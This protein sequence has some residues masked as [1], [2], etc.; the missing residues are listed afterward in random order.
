MH[1][2]QHDEDS[3]DLGRRLPDS[4][5]SE[6][7]SSKRYIADNSRLIALRYID[8]HL[9]LSISFGSRPL[10]FSLTAHFC[11]IS[12]PQQTFMPTRARD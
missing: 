12:N 7:L 10:R 1:V 3:D 4:V 8:K 9:Y 11:Q 6:D 2:A 5:S